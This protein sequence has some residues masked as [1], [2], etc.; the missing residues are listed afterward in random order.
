M[1]LSMILALF[2]LTITATTV[3][4][5]TYYLSSSSGN[6]S[7]NGL[8]EA[9][10]WKSLTKVASFNFVTG[11]SLLL[12][13]GDVF[14]GKMS[15]GGY[16]KSFTVGSFGT[17]TTQ[18]VIA[19]SIPV[20]NWK[21]TTRWPLNTTA[22][23]EADVSGL[24]L[25][26][27]GVIHLFYN[28]ELLTIARY[29]NLPNPST[30]KAK[31]WLKIS[32]N[33][34]ANAF[35][36]VTL[37]NKKSY[38]Y[39][40][41]ATLR[42]RDYSWTYNV[43]TITGYNPTTGKISYDG[44]DLTLKP[45][46]GYFIDGKLEELDN[47][48]EWF[49]DANAKKVYF[50]AYSGIN[51]NTQLIEAE[52]YDI[53]LSIVG[54]PSTVI[55]GISI[56][57]FSKSCIDLII[58]DNVTIRNSNFNY[59]ALA[60]NTWNSANFNFDSNRITNMLN[61]GASLN[62]DSTFNVGT[63]V[64]KNNTLDNIAMF[65]GYGQRKAGLY[66]GFGIDI[67]GAKHSVTNNILNNIG[68]SGIHANGVGGHTI[69]Y[70]TVTNALA[71]LNDGGGIVMNSSNNKILKNFVSNTI[72]NVDDS[73]GL[74]SSTGSYRHTSYGMGIGANESFTNNTVDGNIIAN[75]P[76]WGI[77]FNNFT[78]SK[79]INNVLFNNAGHILLENYG[80]SSGNTISGNIIYSAS[81][82]Q[83]AEKWLNGY[84]LADGY[85]AD[86]YRNLFC[87]PYSDVQFNRNQRFYSFAHWKSRYFKDA[88]STICN[89]KFAE[90][91]ISNIGTNLIV[92]G[93]F[94]VNISG[95]IGGIFDPAKTGMTGGSLKITNLITA[96]GPTV[97]SPSF[98]LQAEVKYR[99][100]FSAIGS[101]YGSL[102]ATIT[103]GSGSPWKVLLE[104]QFAYNSTAQ[105]AE[106]VFTAPAST[107][108][109]IVTLTSYADSSTNYW[110]DNLSLTTIT[111][112]PNRGRAQ[113]L[114]NMTA[115]PV[116]KT[117]DSSGY[118]NLN[119]TGIVGSSVTLPERSGLIIV[120]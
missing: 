22:V 62:A 12:K 114:T 43:R 45:Q 61:R 25:T 19:G 97:V 29:P 42:V 76:S 79:A 58:S 6:D 66:Y 87:N 33:A 117:L 63:S 73:N 1:K 18:P 116:I 89:F 28:N 115:Y 53:G 109:A 21:L 96:N 82:T 27:D 34:G 30:P 57:Q 3:H 50:Y 86:S 49:Y 75:N 100:T 77:R 44:W 67:L 59:C 119:G 11:D 2:S 113:L 31:N 107:T 35:T 78:Y 24:P 14:R 105:N 72:G 41:G 47:P 111:A 83:L 5:T 94:D 20:T 74:A 110:L 48:G 51:P 95:W 65:P 91:M 10:A 37:I 104:R 85:Q 98:A 108:K 92:N 38:D 36:D 54:K 93:N 103:D 60:L 39:W 56:R 7:N 112:I 70:N 118:L 46:W 102:N 8:T 23:Y 32:A 99:L 13:R 64:F 69:S 4:A 15:F 71:L 68:G 55:D 106:W 52:I 9:T 101:S 26:T 90:N 80:K 120:K 40:K 17:S 84:N 88:D 81:A 16:A